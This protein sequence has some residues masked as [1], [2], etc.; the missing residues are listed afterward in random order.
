MRRA[1]PTSE[2]PRRR[3]RSGDF[4]TPRRVA[5]YARAT[6]AGDY[7]A[8]VL[9]VLGDVLPACRTAL[10]VG[11]GFGALT[12]PLA[13]RLDAVTALEPAAAMVTALRTAVARA[14]ARNVTVIEARWEDAR[15]GSHDLVVCAHVGHL[16]EGGSSF[17][18]AL[19]AL[20]GVGAALVADA[21]DQTGKFFF[22][23]LYPRLLGRPYRRPD[24]ACTNWEETA[25]AL[26]RQGQTTTAVPIIYA[27]DQP[28]DSLEEACDFWMDYMGLADAGA[29]AYLRDYLRARL[30]RRG[31]TWVAPFRKRA[32]V[33]IA[34]TRL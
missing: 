25:E 3:E 1:N 28:F 20:T 23:E 8:R 6:A 17:L 19:P 18:A 14:D 7:A 31:E 5:W 34:R 24:R 27:S 26:A 33:V 13:R 4:W 22:D 32:V 30:V 12:L 29:R 15:P 16:L 10:D 21:P 11:A 2:S 9:D